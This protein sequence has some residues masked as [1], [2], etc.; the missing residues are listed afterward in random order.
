[1]LDFEKD[2]H[3]LLA[4]IFFMAQ[5]KLDTQVQKWG[6]QDHTV[7]DWWLIVS[8]EFGELAKAVL[9]GNERGVIAEAVDVIACLARFVEKATRDDPKRLTSTGWVEGRA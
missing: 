8:E 1:M 2:T 6:I 7:G 5:V 3:N 9:E 4:E